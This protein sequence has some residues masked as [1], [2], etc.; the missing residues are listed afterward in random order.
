MTDFAPHQM[1][2]H[3]EIDTYFVANHEIKNALCDKG[4]A[5][6]HIF[7]TGIPISSKFAKNNR[8]KS[9]K[10]TIAHTVLIM[11]GGLGLGAVEKAV[12][13]LMSA[14]T[15]LEIIVVAGNN[16]KLRQRLAFLK[17]DHLHATTIIGY[18]DRVNEL[19]ANSS[20]LITKPGALTCSEALVMELP[21]LLL[22]PI[23]GQEEDNADYLTRQGVALRISQ[24]SSLP[25]VI[26]ELF[27]KP[28]ILAAMQANAH[29]LSRPNAAK[30]I[31][32]ILLDK[33]DHHNAIFPAS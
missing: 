26:D 14:K 31:A 11:G 32:T 15:K 12:V 20:I 25:Q 27:A 8:S 29:L 2:I 3:D 30:E 28:E 22:N 5:D 10:R 19:M 7:V 17:S 6:K 9:L 18:T 24:T 21:M 4:I 1:W 16:I 33:L 23:P 13:S